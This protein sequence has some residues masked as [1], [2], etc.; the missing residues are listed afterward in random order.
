M[1]CPC[2]TSAARRSGDRRRFGPRAT[3]AA[4]PRAA[5]SSAGPRRASARPMD[6]SDRRIDCT[7]RLMDRG[8]DFGKGASWC[9]GSS[10]REPTHGL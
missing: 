8:R 4:F 3:G 10:S 2:R 7:S 5:A 9:V 1:Y 6:D